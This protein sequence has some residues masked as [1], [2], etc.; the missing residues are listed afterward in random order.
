MRF[1]ILV[2]TSRY[3]FVLI[4]RLN[5]LFLSTWKPAVMT[6]SGWLLAFLGVVC[7]YT[8]NSPRQKEQRVNISMYHVNPI[9]YHG[10][11]NMDLADAAGDA[12]FD[13]RGIGI[14]SFCRNSTSHYGLCDNPEAEGSDRVVTRVLIETENKFS[15]YGMCNICVDGTALYSF[16]PLP[17]TVGE[18]V[19][20]CEGWFP[21]IRTKCKDELIG[22]EEITVL[23]EVFPGAPEFFY[24]QANFAQRLEGF[25]YSMSERGE[26][27]TWRLVE[28]QKRVNATCQNKALMSSIRGRNPSC[29]DA[30][31]QPKNMTSD[32]N[33]L[34]SMDVLLG[35]SGG[36]EITGKGGLNGSELTLMWLDAFEA[37]PHLPY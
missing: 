21:F 7:A 22:R 15:D 19:C 12:F 18:Y 6:G 10:V 5:I 33:I 16:P 30:C 3:L 28:E 2:E 8:G 36:S 24:W 29:F 17:C 4:C 31:P 37:C 34:C 11:T 27:K 35:P 25:W 23:G 13:L 14:P 20:V 26:N 32:C 9:R 1:T